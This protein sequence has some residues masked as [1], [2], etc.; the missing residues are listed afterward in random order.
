[1][2][3]ISTMKRAPPRARRAVRHDAVPASDFIGRVDDLA[4]L[5][6]FFEAGARIVTIVGPGGIGKTRLAEEFVAREAALYARAGGG[7]VVFCDLVGAVSS[8]DVSLR[9]AA[10]LQHVDGFMTHA[11]PAELGRALRRR[12]RMLLVLDNFE[13]LVTTA[14]E[15]IV[16]WAQQAQRAHFLVTSRIALGIPGEQLWPL[17]PLSERE[18]GELFVRRAQLLRP[19]LRIAERDAS[20]VADIVRKLEGMPLGIELA[21][22][23]IGV[24]SLDALRER[25]RSPLSVLGSS[26]E[27]EA[28]DERHSSMRRVIEDSFRLL[29]D[30]ARACLCA[31]AVF[32]GAFPLET[33]EAVC[34]LRSTLACIESLV[35]HSL[36]R[37][38]ESGRELRFTLFEPVR[39]FA[40]E[41]LGDDA[42]RLRHQHAIVYAARAEAILDRGVDAL[43]VATPQASLDESDYVAA[44]SVLLGRND[45]ADSVRALSIALLLAPMMAA[46]GRLRECAK[47]LET[48]HAPPAGA[49][50]EL[51]RRLLLAKA[52]VELGRRADARDALTT[53]ASEA[54]V[55]GDHLTEGEATLGLSELIEHDG[56]TTGAR[57]LIG[58][59]LRLFARASARATGSAHARTLSMLTA[60]AFV[61]LGHGLRREGKLGEATSSFA[62][63]ITRYREAALESANER[64]AFA[65]YE[66]AVVAMFRQEYDAARA[67]YDAGLALA[68]QAHARSA[69]GTNWS[70][71]G[72]LAQELGDLD[73]A[74]ECHT[75]SVSVAR[76]TE[77]LFGEGSALYYLACTYAERGQDEDA[78]RVAL[79]SRTVF[80]R[81]SV[82]R[83]EALNHG[84]AAV[85]AT[86]A[87]DGAGARS[88][89]ELAER[90]AN[91]CASETSLVATLAIHRM[92]VEPRRSLERARAI[93]QKHLN[94]DPRLAL[95]LLE[96]RAAAH[97][98]RAAASL[99]IRHEAR[100]FRLPNS[101]C[102]VDLGRRDAIRRILWALARRRID[103]P[104]EP[105]ALDE[106]L[107]AGWPGERMAYQAG[108]NRVYVALN[109]L[110]KLG[111]GEHLL[112]RDRGYCLSSAL[113]VVVQK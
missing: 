57:A 65:L 3:R 88:A 85:L 45:A 62:E 68:R 60:D 21:A 46:R 56:D 96:A 9:L 33:I 31:C 81:I 64:L 14:G 11:S 97:G 34:P 91:A 87:G 12:K 112:T 72:I 53:I 25:L 101:R 70:G 48:T 43:A 66:A 35:H 26:R 102:D 108:A 38:R 95:R 23:R 28:S 84:L 67:S 69:E 41:Q 73:R 30:D 86:R 103:S 2:A 10:A 58:R 15:T 6:R 17:E 111:L 18:A 4:C 79:Q 54:H 5:L 105:M 24:L 99:T 89:L 42:V 37:T 90:A 39:E 29:S 104:G 77:N 19:S 61:R 51:A 71:L 7:G 52:H 106:V 16:L 98:R 44:H 113:S 75:E 100:T 78:R 109:T 36:L 107:A 74:L 93:A 59:A 27:H 13:Q 76:E 22:A 63:A 20:L 47:L 55:E 83:Y 110:R 8:H 1:M 92:H 94:D 40:L 50:G 82:P 49:R 80:Q 32:Q